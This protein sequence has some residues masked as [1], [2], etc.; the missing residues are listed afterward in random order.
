M[1]SPACDEAGRGLAYTTARH[2]QELCFVKEKLPQMKT[3]IEPFRLKVIEPFPMTTREQREASLERA[4]MSVFLL[5]A[6]G[7]LSDL[8]ADSG[9]CTRRAKSTM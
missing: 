7:V 3:I 5:P 6:V 4:G 1:I 2:H 9:A 8:L